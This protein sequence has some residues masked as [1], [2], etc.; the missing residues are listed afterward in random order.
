MI[1]EYKEAILKLWEMHHP[2]NL[3]NQLIGIIK[4]IRYEHI[5]KLY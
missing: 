1:Y 5:E 2:L 3:K 4:N